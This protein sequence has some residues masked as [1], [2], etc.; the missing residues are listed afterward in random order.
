MI[1]VTIINLK[2]AMKYL[3]IISILAIGIG[4]TRFFY[5]SN[6]LKTQIA[7]VSLTRVFR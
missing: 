5:K 7:S 4:I 3:V 2:S 6:L 1:N